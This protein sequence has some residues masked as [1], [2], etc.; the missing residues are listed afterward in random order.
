M[1]DKFEDILCKQ[2]AKEEGYLIGKEYPVWTNENHSGAV[3]GLTLALQ[4]YRIH[5][6]ECPMCKLRKYE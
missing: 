4:L 5:K 6:S 2:I 3:R 1:N